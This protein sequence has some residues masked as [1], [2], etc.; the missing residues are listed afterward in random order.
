[1]KIGKLQNALLVVSCGYLMGHTVVD[2]YA[3]IFPPV[4]AIEKQ[5]TSVTS[6][7]KYCLMKRLVKTNI[8]KV[9]LL[10]T[11]DVIVEE[12]VAADEDVVEIETEVEIEDET[13]LIEEG[14]VEE[15][16]E[17]VEEQPYVDGNV[18]WVPN[19]SG[20]KSYM[21]Y[22][23]ISRWTQYEIQQIA[24][25]N[26]KGLRM[27]DGR[28]CVA[29]GS[30]FNCEIGQAFDLILE[31]G[32]VIPCIMGD[33]KA[34]SDTDGN[35]IFTGN[36]CCTEFIVDMS[37]LDHY[38]KIMGDVSYAYEGWDSPVSMIITY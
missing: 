11:T 36:G 32:V 2:L 24:Y 28:Y 14:E 8:S 25:T 10:S 29:I 17:T 19:N 21:P 5:E 20:F 18:Y 4:V 37:C 38:S 34:D 26:E 23:A 1:M 7:A 9:E 16:I 31:N 13:E 3:D 33:Q 15:E 35:N 27:V 12:E 22:T 6:D 30:H